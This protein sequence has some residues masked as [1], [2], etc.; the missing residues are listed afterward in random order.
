MQVFIDDSPVHVTF[1]EDSHPSRLWVRMYVMSATE[2]GRIARVS[3][4]TVPARL[5]AGG[6]CYTGGHKY[7]IKL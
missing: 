5:L 7:A 6:P 4:H 2:T 3:C 1:E